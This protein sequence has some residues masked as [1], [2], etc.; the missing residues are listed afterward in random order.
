MNVIFEAVEAPLL[1]DDTA[2]GLVA[3]DLSSREVRVIYPALPSNHQTR[4]ILYLPCCRSISPQRK[5]V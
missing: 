2:R 5:D 1:P 3:Q 4:D